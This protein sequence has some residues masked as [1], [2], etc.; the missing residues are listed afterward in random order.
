MSKCFAGKFLEGNVQLSVPEINE[1][2]FAK[3]NFR[4]LQFSAKISEQIK[5]FLVIKTSL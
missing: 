5:F 3:I 4:T 1:I 2:S